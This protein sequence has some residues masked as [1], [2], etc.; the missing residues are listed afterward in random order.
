[1][2]S[3]FVSL[4]GRPNAGKS[5]LLNRLVG[6]KIAITADKPQTTREIIQGVA[7]RPE[8]QIVFL[9]SPGIHRPRS[10][11]NR[12]MMRQVREAL[13]ARDLLL[14]VADATAAFGPEDEEAV[15]LVRSART[16]LLLAL[17]KIDRL[18]RKDVLL[19]LLD[20]YR[21]LHAF[22][23]YL[24][25]SALTGEG[26]EMLADAVEARLPEGPEYFPADY[27]TDQP[28]RH[29]AAELIR[30]QVIRQTRQEIPHSS[31]VAIDQFQEGERLVR[32]AA[33]VYVERSG[34]KGIIIGSKAE[35][36]KQV[37]TLARKE[38]EALFGRKVFL[39]LHVKVRPRWRDSEG[40]LD[41]LDWRRQMGAGQPEEEPR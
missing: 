4:L 13:E 7:H 3:G 2:K 25:I 5:T 15:E 39:E 26:V 37:G 34:Q 20:R 30:E 33:T 35:R 10:G 16:P 27:L 22:E 38:M 24:P 17:N 32:L 14:L 41:Q 12:R 18:E 9:D 36:L 31:A 1:M 11:L 29:L 8:A 6:S 28:L 19:P 21:S 23:E 40:F